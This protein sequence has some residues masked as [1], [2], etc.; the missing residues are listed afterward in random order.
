MREHQT[1][2]RLSLRQLVEQDAEAFC[3]IANQKHIL[4]WMP[5]W[6][7]S[8]EGIRRLIRCFISQYPLANKE[9]ARVMFAVCLKDTGE[10]VGMAGVGNKA[11]VDNE[12]EIAF[13]ISEEYAGKGYITEAA[14]AVSQW[15][16]SF[17]KLDYLMAIVDVGNHPSQKVV[18]KCGFQLIDTRMILN[19]GET[20]QKP[21]HYYRLYNGA[22]EKSSHGSQKR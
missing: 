9:E 1:T 20:E 8:V 4:K 6:K 18:Q 7:S 10:I 21:F 15:A 12:I 19:S 5:D 22:T 13:F 3:K 14:K 16:L 11:E 2:E 17:L